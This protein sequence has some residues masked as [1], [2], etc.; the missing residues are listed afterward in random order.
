MCRHYHHYN[1]LIT[2][3]VQAY[4]IGMC[5]AYFI[6]KKLEKIMPHMVLKNS[7]QTEKIKYQN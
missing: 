3:Q 5:V 2:L 7:D 6:I 4:N 1:C